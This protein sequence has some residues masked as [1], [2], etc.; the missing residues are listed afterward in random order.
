MTNEEAKQILI[1]MLQ[2]R[3]TNQQNEALLKAMEA[4]DIVDALDKVVEHWRNN[5]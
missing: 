2:F 1:T 3:N 5:S 4:L